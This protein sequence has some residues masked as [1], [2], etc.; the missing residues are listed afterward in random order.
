MFSKKRISRIFSF[1]LARLIKI[2]V[3]PLLESLISNSKIRWKTADIFIKLS[4]L[5][6]QIKVLKSSWTFSKYSIYDYRQHSFHCKEETHTAVP[7]CLCPEIVDQMNGWK[8]LC[9]KYTLLA[10]DRMRRTY[11]H[12]I[13][14]GGS[15]ATISLPY[16][17]CGVCL[18][19]RGRLII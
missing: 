12:C 9:E 18:L 17:S 16:F 13:C 2:T 4:A 8:Q 19:T 5:P 11:G 1:F 15:L 3:I 10:S 6:G 14:I 7:L